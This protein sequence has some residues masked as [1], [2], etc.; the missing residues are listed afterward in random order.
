[1][2]YDPLDEPVTPR[3]ALV[4]C[5]GV[6]DR[7]R[8]SACSTRSASTGGRLVVRAPVPL[9]RKITAG[10][11]HRGGAARAD[12]RRVVGSA[13]RDAA[14]TDRRGDVGE[15]EPQTLAASVGRSV[16]CWPT[17][18]RRCSTHRHYRGR[19]SGTGLLRRQTS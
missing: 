18:R 10:L 14:R 9:D 13:G 5:V 11:P 1:V 16:R 3:E 8:S 2:I 17:H 12:S 15:A 6:D 7:A 19:S 4:L